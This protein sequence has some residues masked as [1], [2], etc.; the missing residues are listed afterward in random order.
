M[1]QSIAPRLSVV[2]PD[3][4]DDLQNRQLILKANQLISDG[5]QCSLLDDQVEACCSMMAE[6]CELYTKVFGECGLECLKPYMYYASALLEV[7]RREHGVVQEPDASDNNMA[8]EAEEAGVSATTEQCVIDADE[9]DDEME[10]E[11]TS[12]KKDQ[13]ESVVDKDDDDDEQS[14]KAEPEDESNLRH[15]LTMLDIAILICDK[16]PQCNEVKLEKADCLL[17]KCDVL[18]EFDDFQQAI[19][20]VQQSL[21]I[22]ETVNPQLLRMRAE[23]LYFLGMI[24][25]NTEQYQKAS[26]A[27]TLCV[28][29][30]KERIAEICQNGGDQ[31]EIKELEDIISELDLKL[32]DVKMSGDERLNTFVK[33]ALSTQQT[34]GFCKRVLPD[35][36]Q[37][38]DMTARLVR[39]PTKDSVASNQDVMEE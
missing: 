19:L 15:A 3:L 1:Q 8:V 4:I 38:V 20:A 33:T 34:E 12:T 25:Q 5:K 21:Q 31:T 13:D 29:A 24:F 39:K 10:T 26:E 37:Q 35:S 9:D 27:Y 28:K 2:N 11:E 30:L 22:Q 16:N 18:Q 17:K 32:I 23:S 14:D 7:G 6:A 36:T